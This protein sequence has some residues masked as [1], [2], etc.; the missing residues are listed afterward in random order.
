MSITI[1]LDG[2][3]S[4]FDGYDSDAVLTSIETK[5]IE[6]IKREFEKREIN[7]D[8]IRFR[9]RSKDYLTLLAPNDFD[10]CRIKVGERSVWFSVHGLNLPKEIKNDERFDKVKKTLIHWKVKLGSI[11]EFLENSD[12]I[13]ESYIS[14]RN[15]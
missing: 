5:A 3:K 10:F 4:E 15:C 12:L 7:F 2:V 1:S 14:I 6:Y 8:E 13:A 11:D 9:R